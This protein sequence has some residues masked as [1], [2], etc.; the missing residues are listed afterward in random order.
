[1]SFYARGMLMH[2]ESQDSGIHLSEADFQTITHNMSL[3]D[4]HGEIGV[5]EFE[6]IM[7]SQLKLYIQTR[8][9]DFTENRTDADI[10]FNNICTMKMIYF[11]LLNIAREQDETRQSI[12][13]LLQHLCSA[14]HPPFHLVH[15]TNGRAELCSE[16]AKQ[17]VQA[18]SPA[19]PDPLEQQSQSCR[20]DQR[21]DASH[22]CEQQQVPAS[23][24]IPVLVEDAVP[25]ALASAVCDSAA[26]SARE[27]A[28]VE[29]AVRPVLREVSAILL[30]LGE[31]A[32]DEPPRSSPRDRGSPQGGADTP[33]PVQEGTTAAPIFSVGA[34]VASANA[35]Q[36][37]PLTVRP[38]AASVQPPAVGTQPPA[39]GMKPGVPPAPSSKSDTSES[40]RHAGPARHGGRQPPPELPAGRADAQADGPPPCTPGP[41]DHGAGAARIPILSWFIESLSTHP[42][43]EPSPQSAPSTPARLAAARRQ[44]ARLQKED[45]TA[46]RRSF[47]AMRHCALQESLSRTSPTTATEQ[48]SLLASTPAAARVEAAAAVKDAAAKTAVAAAGIDGPKHITPKR[49]PAEQQQQGGSDGKLTQPLAP[50]PP[51]PPFHDGLAGA[52][53]PGRRVPGAGLSPAQ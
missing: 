28:L 46:L 43:F 23:A 13:H 37:G 36:E 11:E 22:G 41:S 25:S 32:L 47:N 42:A 31:M 40:T 34:F 15:P 30:L 49:S 39:A 29:A 50:P 10:E 19:A 14:G 20:A 1:M 8:L 16:A 18:A 7:R 52:A 24:A 21:G 9:T 4:E 33:Q 53:A 26:E 27:R 5:V 38:P 51:A 3:C 48:S 17:A 6:H 2:L 35:G 44:Q 12:R 45:E